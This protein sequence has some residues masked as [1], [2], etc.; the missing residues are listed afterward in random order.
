M[1]ERPTRLNRG[2]PVVRCSS[3]K[4]CARVGGA[5]CVA[6]SCKVAEC[7]CGQNVSVS[8]AS[9]VQRSILSFF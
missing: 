7:R 8:T 5:Q 9:G 4:R 1:S 2:W 6:C 3:C